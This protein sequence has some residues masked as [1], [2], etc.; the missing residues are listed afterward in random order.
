[1]KYKIILILQLFVLQ[2]FGQKDEITYFPKVNFHYNFSKPFAVT[3]DKINVRQSATTSSQVIDSLNIGEEVR[4]TKNTTEFKT[5]QGL[6]FPFVK[7]KYKKND[8]LRN[9][10]VWLGYLT[11][12]YNHFNKYKILSSIDKKYKH[13]NNL[14]SID[15]YRFKIILVDSSNSFH[16]LFS[17]K[18]GI[19]EVIEFDSYTT[20]NNIV[21]KNYNLKNEISVRLDYISCCS[22]YRKFTYLFTKNSL[23]ELPVLNWDDQCGEGIERKYEYKLE[24]NKIKIKDLEGTYFYPD[25][26]KKPQLNWKLK[27]EE[28]LPLKIIHKFNG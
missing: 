21:D 1:M 11:N 18:I 12:S 7:I 16:I 15:E 6:N 13:L 23:I 2:L 25:K 26:N 27:K 28:I 3:K 24:G 8:T 20:V 5:I 9:G 4:V 17:D 14:N 19:E 10:F 22:S